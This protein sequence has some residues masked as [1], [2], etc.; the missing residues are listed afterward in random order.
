VSVVDSV[1]VKAPPFNADQQ[2]STVASLPAAHSKGLPKVAPSAPKA[3]QIV[4]GSLLKS[5]ENKCFLMN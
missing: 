2:K 3:D 5:V 4:C 1:T